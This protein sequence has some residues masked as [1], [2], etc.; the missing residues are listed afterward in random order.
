MPSKF[1]AQKQTQPG[2][3][4]LAD[5][6]AEGASA[7]RCHHE[8]PS[9][10]PGPDSGPSSR[11]RTSRLLPGPA[12]RAAQPRH[13]DRAA[14]RC[15]P[16]RAWPYV[17]RAAMLRLP[18][19]LRGERRSLLAALEADRRPARGG[20][21][22]GGARRCPGGLPHHPGAER[23]THRPAAPGLPGLLRTTRHCCQGT[24]QRLNRQ[25]AISPSLALVHL[26]RSSRSPD[27]A[28]SG[29]TG[30]SEPGSPPWG[31]P[32]SRQLTPGEVS[33]GCS[34]AFRTGAVTGITFLKRPRLWMTC[35][36]LSHAEQWRLPDLATLCD[37]LDPLHATL[38]SIH[39]AY[40]IDRT[41]MPGLFRAAARAA[42]L[43]L[44]A[45]AG[46]AIAALASWK[47][48][49][50]SVAEMA[51]R[52][53][54][55]AAS[56]L[57]RHQAHPRSTSASSSTLSEP[58]QHGLPRLP[59]MCSCKPGIRPSAGLSPS[60]CPATAL[61]PAAGAT[62]PSSSWPTIPILPARPS[63]MLDSGDPPVRVGAAAAS[64]IL[65]GQQW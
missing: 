16:T 44:P 56:R 19:S 5:A 52:P 47:A 64:R 63:S 42:G 3:S 30:V 49:D 29:F 35:R 14:N 40:T 59:A 46:Q 33:R 53:S 9:R 45:L 37:I 31:S 20:H 21:G 60:A 38:E 25:S 6:A 48:G 36:A 55:I 50:Q 11:E 65:A 12:G 62:P 26:P 39:D 43:E 24:L 61:I 34:A 17:R 58:R 2:R 7:E 13:A 23:S 51:A 57:R 54:A 28:R 15:S 10:P 27:T 8:R 41:R 22:P 18:A 1:S 4:S 32:T